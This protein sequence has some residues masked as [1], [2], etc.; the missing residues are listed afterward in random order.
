[1][2]FP[3]RTVHEDID[4]VVDVICRALDAASPT[5]PAKR[6]TLPTRGREETLSNR[7]LSR[8]GIET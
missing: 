3:T 2:R 6:A 1:L 7:P 8:P 4:A 5:R